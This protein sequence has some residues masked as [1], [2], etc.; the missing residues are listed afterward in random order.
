MLSTAL[1][2]ASTLHIFCRK[3]YRFP[4]FQPIFR[5]QKIVHVHQS[6][7]QNYFIVCIKYTFSLSV[8]SFAWLNSNFLAFCLISQLANFVAGSQQHQKN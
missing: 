6:D 8:E 5:V 2:S 3:F 1:S 4:K 7:R